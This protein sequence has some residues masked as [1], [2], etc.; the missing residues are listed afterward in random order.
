MQRGIGL[1][2]LAARTLLS[3]RIVDKIDEGRFSE[4]PGG[5]YARSYIRAFASAVGL[6]PEDAVRELAERLPSAEDPL[7]A[8]REIARSGDPFWLV[9]LNDFA[10]TVRTRVAAVTT[11][12]TGST[13]RTMAATIDALV[14][15]ILQAVLIQ[16]TAWTCG[17][18]PQVLLEFG[19]GAI[20]AV[21]G[22]LVML[23]FVMLG[24]IGKTPGAFMSQLPAAE[25][26]ARLHLPAIPGRALLH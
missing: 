19:S 16:V 10:L 18:H 17:V 9:A 5:L 26:T 12:W 20:A 6:D 13:R 8:L 25:E 14:L 11:A 4:L 15:L 7:P 1:S 2:E 22:I 21:W 24:G 23:Y 3:P